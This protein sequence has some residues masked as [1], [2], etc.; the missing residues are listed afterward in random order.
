MT[1]RDASNVTFAVL[2]YNGSDL[3]KVILPSIYAQTAEGFRVNV[4]DN[5]STDDSIELIEREWP[6]TN[7]V[8]IPENIGVTRALN[9]AIQS[10]DTEYVALLNNDIELEPNWIAEML[11]ELERHPEAAVADS[12]MLNFFRRDE[13]DGA[14]DAMARTGECRKRG[15]GEPDR[16]QYEQPEEIFSA[17]GGA[18]VYRRRVFDEIGFFDEDFYAYY[19]DVD[20]GF[21]ARLRGYSARY[22]PSAVAYHMGS[23]TTKRDKQRSYTHYLPRNS[24]LMTLK[25]FPA[26][27][28]VRHGPRVVGYQLKWLAADVRDRQLRLHLKG[29]REAAAL[30]PA[31]LRKRRE[32]QRLRTVAPSELDRAMTA[33]WNGG[34]AAR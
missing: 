4:I 2:N 19:E 16:G 6:E 9:R 3:L 1:A 23:A 20:W 7:V 29:W 8:R 12:K 27:S 22:V 21:R 5:G 13:I 24:L 17:S 34:E 18:A 30:L 31:T 28:L 25:N 10:A 26:Q 33:R 32:L 11:A 15:F 14:G